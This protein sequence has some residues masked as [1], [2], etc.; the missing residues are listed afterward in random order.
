MANGNWLF[1]C[2]MTEIP[3]RAALRIVVSE[4]GL[5]L[6]P[7][8]LPAMVAAMVD[9]MRAVF[10]GPKAYAAGI[11]MGNITPTNDERKIS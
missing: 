10:V 4:N 8:L 9:I 7:A 1:V 6:S 2:D 5:Q 3:L 11:L